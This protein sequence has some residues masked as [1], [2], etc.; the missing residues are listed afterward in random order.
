M[1]DT[2]EREKIWA[3]G[4]I[5]GFGARSYLAAGFHAEYEEARDEYLGRVPAQEQE[6]E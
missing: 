1:T 2:A 3:E 6:M 4:W 5:R